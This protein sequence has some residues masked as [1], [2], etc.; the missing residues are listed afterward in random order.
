[1]L[2]FTATPQLARNIARLAEIARVL[3][4]YGLA[5]WLGRLDSK[6]VQRWTRGTELAR[7]ATVTHEAR[8][9]LV[10]TELGTTF[11]KFGQV[12]ST[13]LDLIGPALAD[14]LALLQS[15]VPADPFPVTRATIEAELGAPLETLFK[16]FAPE[17]IASGSI[18]QVHRAA[19]P[20]GR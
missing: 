19:L 11:I 5:D 14:E 6:F 13:R 10:L 1:M 16:T 8:I 2:D 9:R 15:S 12:L 4:K 7:L 20:D 18:G 17:P 3:A